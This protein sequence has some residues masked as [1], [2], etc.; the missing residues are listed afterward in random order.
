[1]ALRIYISNGPLSSMA[2]D[3][4]SMGKMYNVKKREGDLNVNGVIGLNNLCRLFHLNHLATVEEC[5]N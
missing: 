4:C 2:R 5:F 1:V 3:I